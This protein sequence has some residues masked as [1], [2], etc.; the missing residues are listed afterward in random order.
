[1]KSLSFCLQNLSK[2]D[3]FNI[4]RF[5]TDVEP[6]FDSLV[7]ADPSHVDR[8]QEFVDGLAPLG[9][10]AINDALLKALAMRPRDSQRPYILIF[11]TDGLPT[12]GVC[13]EEEIVANFHHADSGAT[14]IFCFGL[15]TDVNTHLLD[16][17]AEQ[18]N[19][20]SQYV[21]PDE[22]LELKLA[23]FYTKIKEP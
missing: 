22:D 13:G 15:G 14:R 7:D 8:A 3:R 2:Q 17:L 19:A 21:L 1:K 5:S 4:I 12:V 11:I 18:T 23:D 9:A 16:R 6:L 10:T 20:I